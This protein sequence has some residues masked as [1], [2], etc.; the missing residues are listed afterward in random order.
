[1]GRFQ[2]RLFW[3]G[4][5]ESTRLYLDLDESLSQADRETGKILTLRGIHDP[6]I[7]SAAPV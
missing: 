6:T 3:P 5:V 4:T 7:H 1:V 2:S